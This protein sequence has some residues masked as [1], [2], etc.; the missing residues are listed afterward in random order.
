MDAPFSEGVDKTSN[1]IVKSRTSRT[2]SSL[3]SH[4]SRRKRRSIEVEE[5][6]RMEDFESDELDYF[7]ME[8]EFDEDFVGNVG[9][10]HCMLYRI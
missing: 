2:T 6:E 3:D 9:L 5:E 7:D 1:I 4:S 8:F 10:G